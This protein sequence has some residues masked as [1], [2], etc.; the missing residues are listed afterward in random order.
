VAVDRPCLE[1]LVHLI[2]YYG[3]N[4]VESWKK[5]VANVV[6]TDYSRFRAVESLD[7]VVVD[8]A[9]TVSIAAAPVGDVVEV[10]VF[11]A[12]VVV[13]AAVAE[14]VVAAVAAVFVVGAAVVAFD[15]VGSVAFERVFVVAVAHS[16]GLRVVDLEDC[17][18]M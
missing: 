11:S 8:A 12:V 1:L 18:E 7:L 10:A 9:T 6:K 3:M 17:N 5:E 13:V 14:V 15:V 4:F 2:Y 16:E